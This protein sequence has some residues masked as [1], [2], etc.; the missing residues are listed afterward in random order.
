VVERV[1]ALAPQREQARAYVS[2]QLAAHRAQIC[3]FGIDLPD[4]LKWQW[5]DPVGPPLWQHG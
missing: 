3:E 5:T 4:I 2:G 1:P